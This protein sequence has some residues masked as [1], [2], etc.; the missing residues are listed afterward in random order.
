M[1]ETFTIEYGLKK[2]SV[3]TLWNLVS[4]PQGLSE[5]MADR[6]D[7]N[8]NIFTFYWGDS[9]EQA[10]LLQQVPNERIRFHWLYN[11]PSNY[12]EIRILT[13]ELTR[14]ITLEVTDHADSPEERLDQI[15]LWDQEIEQLIRRTGL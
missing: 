10:E 13:S 15:R 8:G 3:K 11:T 12:F 1:R 2:G 14:D 7:A 5:W 6:V 4:T 9:E